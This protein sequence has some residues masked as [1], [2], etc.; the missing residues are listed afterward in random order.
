MSEQQ[1]PA[2]EAGDEVVADPAAQEQETTETKEPE[3]KTQAEGGSEG[4]ETKSEASDD[5][6]VSPSKARR[7][8]RKAEM[9]RLRKEKADAERVAEEY[10]KRFETLSGGEKPAPKREDFQ[11]YDEWQAELAAH[12]V[13]VRMS[14]RE[15]AEAEG[16]TK[17]SEDALKRIEEREQRELAQQWA[18][19]E[20]DAR[21]RYAD[22]EAVTRNPSLQITQAMMQ[23]MTASEKGP[24]V[25]Y[26]LGTNPDVSARIAAMP[27][28]EA[29]LEIGRIEA[30]LSL[31]KAPTQTKAPDPV[32][33]VKG[34]T[35]SVTKD[36]E[37]MSALEWR[38]FRESGGSI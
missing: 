11:D 35:A 17:E 36:P 28:L 4:G 37:K 12:K 8:R 22:Y 6:K 16:K 32:T 33:P 13:E 26:W 15:R 5:E 9:E 7:E 21:S 27:P 2:P 29:A 30:H 14:A 1:T 31:P 20:A 18:D 23:A 10:R 25:A 19:Q 34:K 38:K 3:A 24:D